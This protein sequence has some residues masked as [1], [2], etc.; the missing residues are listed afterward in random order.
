MTNGPLNRQGSLFDITTDDESWDDS[1]WG[2]AQASTQRLFNPTQ[3]INE[4][5]LF[6]G[7]IN[8]IQDILDVIYDGGAHA[9]IHGERGVGKSSLVNIIKDRIPDAISN[10]RIMKEN[11]TREDS[12]FSL[13][14]KIM[15]DFE[16]GSERVPDLLRDEKRHF[17]VTKILEALPTDTQYLFVFDEFDRVDSAATKT[18]IADTIKHFSDYPQNITIIIV[19]VGFSV[20]ELFGAHPSIER[21]C[22]QVAMPR[23]SR[24]ELLQIMDDRLPQ[25]GLHASDTTKSSIIDVSQGFPGFV[26]LVARE[27]SLSAIRRLSREIRSSDYDNAIREAVKRAHESLVQKYS[28]AIY[29]AKANIYREVLLACA[30]ARPNEMGKFSASD[31]KAPLSQLLNRPVEISNFARHLARFCSEERGPILRKTG[32]PKRF[33]Y[34]FIDAPLQPYIIMVGKKD[35]LL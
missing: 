28:K 32:K 14:S 27:A 16:F 31:V 22:R 7:R 11:C 10:L 3:P 35:G 4:D 18:A 33:Q 12:Y 8:Q 34:Q 17:I 20:E 5:R 30:K 15:F 2:L 25:I 24:K 21:C 23:M 6:S 13:W 29:S 1:R 26:H 19:G 9:I